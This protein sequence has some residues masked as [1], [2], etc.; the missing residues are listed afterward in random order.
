[1]AI[2]LPGIVREE[3]AALNDLLGIGDALVQATGQLREKSE[4]P[5]LDAELLLALALDVPRSYLFAHP[6]DRLDPAAAERFFGNVE[7]RCAGL[8][9]AYITGEK[10][11]WSLKL[12]VSPD[13]LVPR[14][15][16]EVLVEQALA[17][18]P[19]DAHWRVLDLGTGSGAIALAIARERPLCLLT[20]TDVSRG[21]LAVAREN[22]RRLSIA[23]IE[24]VCGHWCAPL[25]GVEFDLIVSNPPYVEADDP[26]LDSLRHEPRGALAAGPDGLDAIR[27]ISRQA[28][29]LLKTG[30][31]LLI[32]HGA[33]QADAVASILAADGW[34][35]I[36]CVADLAG[37]PRMT[38]AQR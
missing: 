36:R 35:V 6:E 33:A 16:T 38:A 34:Y 2:D 18:V 7:K 10:E 4:T 5:R 26:H 8:P 32:E 12:A 20:A 25:Q 27:S 31:W 19:K 17:R 21:A 13:A 1:M 11:F 3:P 29:N 22:A 24:F 30:G 23:N 14:P 28:G 15:E 37:L 9:L